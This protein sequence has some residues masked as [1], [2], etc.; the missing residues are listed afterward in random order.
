VSGKSLVV[1]RAL[2]E[3]AGV[4]PGPE[5]EAKKKVDRKA[6]ILWDNTGI[7]QGV[8]SGCGVGLLLGP[9]RSGNERAGKECRE[10][11]SGS[12][13]AIPDHYHSSPFAPIVR[14]LHL[15]LPIVAPR[16]FRLPVLL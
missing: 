14:Q 2:A 5:R 13:P 15:T 1:F 16:I 10:E 7:G 4:P 12:G 8:G 9:G 3:N 11:Y 6:A